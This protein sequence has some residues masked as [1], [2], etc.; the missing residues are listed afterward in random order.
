MLTMERKEEVVVV[1]ME[2]GKVNALDLEMC[3]GLTAQFRELEQRAERAVVLT[4]RKSV[5][6]AGVDLLQV[7]D[8][9]SSYVR[10]FLAAFHE[11]CA[12]LFGFPKPLVTAINGHAIAGG[13]VL[14]CTA[15]RRIMARGSGRV[16]IPEL[17]VG[18]PFPTAPLEI[19]RFAT[20]ARHFPHLLYGGATVETDAA[21]DRGLVD[22]VVDPEILLGRAVGT[23]Q[24]MAAMGAE[25]FRLT[26]SQIRSPILE[27]IEH[28]HRE[29]GAAVERIWCSDSTMAAIQDYVS[30][31]FKRADP[32][33]TS[34]E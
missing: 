18:V 10:P 14:A 22:E 1:R 15:D 13:C 16:G 3:R 8:G 4:G 7:L 24:E 30:R 28:G 26:K 27:A 32:E 2:H 17:R 19:M 11:F 20:P 12:T 33:V 34:Q 6:S 31:T 29:T 5:F 25:N 9:G 21:V 23:A